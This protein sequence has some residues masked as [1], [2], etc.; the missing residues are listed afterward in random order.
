M[1]ACYSLR[2][3]IAQIRKAQGLTQ[4]QLAE[5]AG[6]EVVTLSR[7]E[8]AFPGTTLRTL[9]AT[10]QALDAPLP[11]ITAEGDTYQRH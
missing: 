3:V 11:E 4:E 10:S 5:M 8:N 7:A 2:M 1:P 6:I 9:T